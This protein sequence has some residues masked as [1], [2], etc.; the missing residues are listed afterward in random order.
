MRVLDL[1]ASGGSRRRTAATPSLLGVLCFLR[2]HPGE[3]G[4]DALHCSVK[5]SDRAGTN[6]HRQ[7]AHVVLPAARPSPDD[8]HLGAL[9]GRDDVL[10]VLALGPDELL[11][12]T[13]LAVILNADLDA[14]EVREAL[15]G[16]AASGVLVRLPR[17]LGGG[18]GSIARGGLGLCH[19]LLLLGL[20]LPRAVL[21]ALRVPGLRAPLGGLGLGQAAGGGGSLGV[22][23]RNGLGRGGGRT[24]ARRHRGAHGRRGA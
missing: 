4:L 14:L 13:E 5:H 21:R 12:Y 20:G 22:S 23:R 8:P 9:G 11:D 15:A 7:R 16:L 6:T 2:A 19:P 24:R 1:H 18:R 17:G 3:Q 10:H